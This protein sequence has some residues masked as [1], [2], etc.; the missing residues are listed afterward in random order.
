MINC[1]GQPGMI[2]QGGRG[3]GNGAGKGGISEGEKAVRGTTNT[4]LTQ[5]VMPDAHL[6]KKSV[7]SQILV[8]PVLK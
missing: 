2:Y 3:L 7:A 5:A 4:V 6:T 8:P 1:G